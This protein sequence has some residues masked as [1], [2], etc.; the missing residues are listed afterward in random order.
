[1]KYRFVA[2]NAKTWPINVMC[3]VLAISTSGYY[4][5]LKKP[6]CKRDRDDIRYRPLIRQIFDEYS[7]IYGSPRI[8]YEM[9]AM[10]Y[11]INEKRVE[12]L[13]REMGLTASSP[14]QFV[15]TTDSKHDHP[16]AENLLEQDFTAEEPNQKWVGDI[17]YIATKEGWLYLATVIDLFSRKIV[18]WA[19]SDH[20]DTE[21]VLSAL[22]MGIRD[23]QPCE[24]LIFHSDRGSQYASHEYRQ[25][26]AFHGI[27]QSMSRRACCW[28]N[29]VAESFFHSLKTEW[30]RRHVYENR[31][32]ARTSI[33][34]YIHGFYN[35]KRRHST[36]GYLSPDEYEVSTGFAA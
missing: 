24:G 14:K 12:R 22:R 11:R 23:R 34:A 10:G 1:M 36:I 19:M 13:M 7:G 18:G 26:L 4:K 32:T 5:W 21:L 33:F 2:E 15:T 16:I 20:I 9:R 28:D 17:T 30:I 8:T 31:E 29:A 27:T 3:A 6:A 25:T 35:S